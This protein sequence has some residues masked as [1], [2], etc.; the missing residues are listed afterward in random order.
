MRAKF[1]LRTVTK[2]HCSDFYDILDCLTASRGGPLN[3][4]NYRQ[5]LIRRPQACHGASRL[6]VTPA[7][8][9]ANELSRQ[10]SR[11]SDRPFSG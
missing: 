3:L 9:I 10:S 1:H 7:R 11:K 5:Q 6:E 4:S 8:Q 2:V